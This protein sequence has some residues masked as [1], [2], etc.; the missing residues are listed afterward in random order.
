MEK[1]RKPADTHEPAPDRDVSTYQRA[2][3]T[4]NISKTPIPLEISHP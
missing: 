2:A 3:K 4:K 1:S